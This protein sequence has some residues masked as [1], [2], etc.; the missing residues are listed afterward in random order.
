MRELVIDHFH[1]RK[2]AKFIKELNKFIEYLE[3]TCRQYREERTHVTSREIA[4]ILKEFTDKFESRWGLYPKDKNMD[5]DTCVA[6]IMQDLMEA[7]KGKIKFSELPFP[8]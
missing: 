4:H 5:F 7:A 8:R 6:E 3:E 2:L 1:Q